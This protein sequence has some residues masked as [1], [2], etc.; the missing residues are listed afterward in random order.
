LADKPLGGKIFIDRPLLLGGGILIE[1]KKRW[2]IFDVAVSC[3]APIS[4]FVLT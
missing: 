3:H 4:R 1:F 2:H